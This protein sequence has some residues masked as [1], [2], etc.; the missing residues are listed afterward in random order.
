MGNL[1]SLKMVSF[2]FDAHKQV[3]WFHYMSYVVKNLNQIIKVKVCKTKPL[4]I[5]QTPSLEI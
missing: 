1:K 2:F 4:F 3:E 5:D